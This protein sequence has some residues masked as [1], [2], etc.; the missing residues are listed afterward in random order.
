MLFL[1]MSR[2]ANVISIDLHWRLWFYFYC[3]FS[4]SKEKQKNRIFCMTWHSASNEM[5]ANMHCSHRSLFATFSSSVF[6]Q[7]FF[8]LVL[9]MKKEISHFFGLATHSYSIIPFHMHN[10][11]SFFFSEF[12]FT[13]HF[14][15]LMIFK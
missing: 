11:H 15:R 13:T 8:F 4:T 9:N 6:H 7:S 3:H 5:N 2:D 1:W 10:A 12:K 14:H